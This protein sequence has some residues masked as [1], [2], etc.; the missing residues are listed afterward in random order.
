MISRGVNNIIPARPAS[1]G[2]GVKLKRV[3]NAR[4]HD[5]MDPFLM[6][7]EIRSDDSGDLGNGFPS[8]PH[9]GIETLS[10]MLKGGFCHQDHLGNQRAIQAGGMQWMKAGKGIVHSELPISDSGQLHGFQIWLNLPSKEKMSA[11]EYKDLEPEQVPVLLTDSMSLRLL[12]GKVRIEGELLSSPVV[13]EP[14]QALLMDITL[15]K[16]QAV[17]LPLTEEK[18]MLYVYQGALTVHG[19][20]DGRRVNSSEL[21][22]LTEGELLSMSSSERCGFLVLGGTP[23]KEPVVQYGPFVMNTRE[24]IDQAI[25][26]Y[27]EGTFLE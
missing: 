4:L 26:E 21:A 22:V 24:E 8:H 13:R 23:L 10:V 19:D 9:R 15:E 3:M 17:D 25:R 11:P 14:T 7:D 12:V 2:A 16:G 6:L 20:Q 1:D 18:L 27:Q 5:I